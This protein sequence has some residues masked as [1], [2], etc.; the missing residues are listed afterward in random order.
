MLSKIQDWAPVF[1]ADE[2]KL[3][4]EGI[5]ALSNMGAP[6]TGY[7]LHPGD[8][9]RFEE[10]VTAD[11]LKIGKLAPQ[12]GRRRPTM[13]VPV[14]INDV[15]T[16]L[17]PMFFFRQSR[18]NNQNGQ[19]YPEWAKLGDCKRVV[20]QLIKQGGIN[21]PNETFSTMVSSFDGNVAKYV[22]EVDE[23]GNPVYNAD[24]TVKQ[25]RATEPREFPVLPNPEL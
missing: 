11:S 24:G 23:K 19:V 17:N 5:D 6:A 15:K 16:F 4:T 20:A 22:P 21:V 1:G 12:E 13:L 9:L 18:I 2:R 10:G 25:I 14:I 7:G 3:E 8:K